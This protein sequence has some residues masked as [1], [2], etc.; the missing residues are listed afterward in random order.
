LSFSRPL[1]SSLCVFLLTPAHSPLPLLSPC[2]NFITFATSVRLHI[3]SCCDAT[4][5]LN[6]R[7]HF[8]AQNAEE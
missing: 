8:P 1:H 3:L 7:H 2:P 6:P 5:E 4:P